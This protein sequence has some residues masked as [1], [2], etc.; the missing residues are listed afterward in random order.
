M[1]NPAPT[2]SMASDT[3][4]SPKPAVGRPG[5]VGVSLRNG[6]PNPAEEAFAAL[7]TATSAMGQLPLR[8]LGGASP[9]QMFE[10]PMA[11][12]H[13]RRQA[14]LKADDRT[15]PQRNSATE[16]PDPTSVQG[17]RAA[18]AGER[19]PADPAAGA[20]REASGGRGR[21]GATPG[22]DRGLS[23]SAGTER[24]GGSPA[25]PVS[26][27]GDLKLSC[28]S[29]VPSRPSALAS[30]GGSN[31]GESLVSTVPGKTD[32]GSM[33]PVTTGRAAQP[34]GQLARQVAEILSTGRVG[35]VESPRA[36]G[37]S[38]RTDGA[39]QAAAG[40]KG[41]PSAA[42]RDAS[43]NTSSR[44]TGE[45]PATERTEFDQ[46][47]RALRLRTGPRN[48][49]ARL[50]LQPPELGR[51]QVDVR[52]TGNELRIGVQTETTEAR[53][54]LTQRAAALTAALEQWGLNVERLE[55]TVN[56]SNELAQGFVGSGHPDVPS[57]SG[58]PEHPPRSASL[59]NRVFEGEI[60]PSLESEDEPEPT[61]VAE[62]RLDIRV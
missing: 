37:L 51:I 62:A 17:R 34:G 14:A 29:E 27:L 42:G 5:R 30:S 24:S 28:L 53:N 48:S 4:V 58:R 26:R 11:D 23:L 47:I 20:P 2:S 56:F 21:A 6:D 54:L 1:V 10:P 38:G 16:G 46:L 22:G 57:H 41:T 55:I 49:S 52:M 36:V 19:E 61:V 35:E 59:T 32:V 60:G 40:Q 25:S 44:T 3:N 50:Y 8:D 7:L 18:R 9:A 33:A 15:T 13:E 39:R 45:A 31:S 12:A 43:G